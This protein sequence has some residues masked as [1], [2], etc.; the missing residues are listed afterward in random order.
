MVPQS[1]PCQLG[2]QEVGAYRYNTLSIRGVRNSEEG[3]NSTLRETHRV[4]LKHVIKELNNDISERDMQNLVVSIAKSD[5]PR[6]KAKIRN[7]LVELN[8]ELSTVT[9]TQEVVQ[10]HMSVA[11]LAT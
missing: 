9:S 3:Q 10:I 6:I 4:A 7:F 2:G 1:P 8:E 5:M 11:K